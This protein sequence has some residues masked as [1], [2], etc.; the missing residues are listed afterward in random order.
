MEK[1]A[2]LGAGPGGLGIAVALKLNGHDVSVFTRSIER[3]QA[4]QEAG[5]V[6]FEGDHG[7]DTGFVELPWVTHDP[8]KALDSRD[9]FIIAVP[10]YGQQYMAEIALPWLK[11]GNILLLTPGCAG[12]LEVFES[13]KCKVDFVNEV[14]LGET[15][16]LPQAARML[17]PNKIKIKWRVHLNG[18]FSSPG[19]VAAFPGQNTPEI[20]NRLNRAFT[21]Q[22]GKNVLDTGLNNPNFIIH[23]APMT[24]NYAEVERRD[25]KLSLMNEGMTKGVLAC[26]DAV[27]REKQAVSRA[28]GNDPLDI[29]SVYRSYGSSP[30][31][32]REPGEPMGLKDR[33]WSRYIEEDVPYG[34]V[35]ISS[36]GS[37]LSVPTPV[38]DGINHLLSVVESRDF[39]QDGRTVEKLGIAGMSS[40]QLSAYLHTGEK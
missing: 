39:Y 12:S 7:P 25:G 26:M 28:I 30:S 19:R 40:D 10:A 38:C 2:V 9:I 23:P 13:L 29:D 18:D 11:P 1:I 21:V 5:G 35:M 27:D 3:I 17:S 24:L 36:I 33:I 32:Y 4:I 14:L 15:M 34:T 16:S 37:M 8:Q 20:L 22:T 31:V 6:H